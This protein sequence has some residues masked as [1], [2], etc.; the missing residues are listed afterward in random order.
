M[1][2]QDAII[3]TVYNGKAQPLR[4]TIPSAY[5]NYDASAW[6]YKYDLNTAKQMLTDAGVPAGTELNMLVDSNI[7]ED[8]DIAVLIQDSL[9]KIGIKSTID[10]KPTAAYRDDAA[11]KEIYNLVIAQTYSLV[12]DVCYHMVSFISKTG[13][14]SFNHYAYG[15][16]DDLTA[17]CNSLPTGPARD[18]VQK[19]L[20]KMVSEE[21]PTL[22]VAVAPGLWAVRSGIKGFTWTPYNQIRFADLY[23]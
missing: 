22:S 6:P 4:N 16:F 11:N 17:K 15:P 14:V 7:P 21:I 23:K 8:Q 12:I 3:K 10:Q 13:S 1:I 18:Q 20:Q 19:D 2:D 5:P 9:S